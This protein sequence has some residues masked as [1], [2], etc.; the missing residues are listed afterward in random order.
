MSIILQQ[1]LHVRFQVGHMNLFLE[2][3]KASYHTELLTVNPSH[4][5]SH[6]YEEECVSV[7]SLYF[8][9][10]AF[11]LTKFGLILEDLP[12]EVP[13][14]S[15]PPRKF[16]NPLPQTIFAYCLRTVRRCILSFFFCI[17]QAL[18]KQKVQH[19]SVTTT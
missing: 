11:I 16:W 7:C 2:M 10:T 18:E 6:S 3:N 14:T 13:D 8:H 4:V 1:L 12:R 17:P 15:K 19:G 5:I 9:I